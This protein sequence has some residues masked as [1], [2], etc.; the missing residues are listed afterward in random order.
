MVCLKK[1]KKLSPSPS[2]PHPDASNSRYPPVS[3]LVSI[4]QNHVYS[5]ACAVDKDHVDVHGLY[6]HKSYAEVFGMYDVRGHMDALQK[7]LMGVFE[8]VHRL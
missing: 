4:P 8:L 6:C 3:I 7:F 5:L 2:A 1:K